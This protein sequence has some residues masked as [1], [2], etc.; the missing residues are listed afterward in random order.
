MF[1]KLWSVF[2]FF[3]WTVLNIWK[4]LGDFVSPL[5]RVKE[6]ATTFAEFCE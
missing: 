4:T 2:Y 6:M 5:V 1:N 3:F